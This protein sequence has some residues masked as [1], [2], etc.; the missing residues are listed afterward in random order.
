MNVCLNN[1][2]AC[3]FR[4]NPSFAAHLTRAPAVPAHCGHRARPDHPHGFPS[5][6]TL[7]SGCSWRA[8]K[9]ERRP[10]HTTSR[11]STA[12]T[13]RSSREANFIG[14][15]TF[16]RNSGITCQRSGSRVAHCKKS[17]G[18]TPIGLP[19]Y[20]MQIQ[21]PSMLSK[22]QVLVPPYFEEIVQVALERWPVLTEL[23]MDT[24]RSPL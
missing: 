20:I 17:T 6:Q 3:V 22:V 5:T 12:R 18:E 21:E 11:K 8:C 16:R 14:R 1:P 2:Q 23:C 15:Q 10:A 7:R 24:W 19:Q 4:S 9:I 13:R